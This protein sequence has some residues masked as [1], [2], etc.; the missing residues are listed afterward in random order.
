MRPLAIDEIAGL[1]GVAGDVVNPG[2]TRDV[3][4]VLE[5]SAIVTGRVLLPGNLPAQGVVV[6]V[7]IPK[8][9]TEPDHHLFAQ[10]DVNGTFTF[11]AVPSGGPRTFTFDDP[12][13][14]ICPAPP[15][16]N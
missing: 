10:S 8:P 11:P 3:R 9:G 14:P 7:V 12:I 13:G 5:P 6:E 15:P 2:G 1:K 16:A 4:I